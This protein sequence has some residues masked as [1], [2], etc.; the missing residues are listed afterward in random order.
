MSNNMIL[1]SNSAVVWYLRLCLTYLT[2][3]NSPSICVNRLCLASSKF[4]ETSPKKEIENQTKILDTY[5][6]QSK[7]LKSEHDNF[8]YSAYSR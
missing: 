2:L 6:W 3:P 1:K 5:R 8:G 7:Y 4:T